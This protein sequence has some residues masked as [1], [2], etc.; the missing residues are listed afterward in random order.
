MGEMKRLFGKVSG[1]EVFLYTLTNSKGMN[2]E[3]SPFGAVVYS[4]N[5]ADKDGLYVDVT[6]GW[7]DLDGYQDNRCFYGAA[8]GRYANRIAG[9]RFVLGG[10]EYKLAQNDGNNHLHGGPKGYYNVLWD[11][12]QVSD[13]SITLIY[14][15]PDG[16]E[17]YPGNL[18][19]SL[20][21]T[22]T[23]DNALVLDY[24]AGSDA[25]TIVNLTNHTY[26]NLE[27]H[28]AGYIGE[29]IMQIFADR[30]IPTDDG[31]IP[32]GRLDSV[33]GTPYDFTRPKPIG[34]DIN[35]PDQQLKNGS[36]YDQCFVVSGERVGEHHGKPVR[37]CAQV[38]APGKRHC[39][40][41]G[42]YGRRTAVLFRQPHGRHRQTG[43][44]LR[45]ERSLLSGSGLFSQCGQ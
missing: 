40:A 11:V 37:L 2:V 26:F 19:I 43:N 12:A 34:L 23:E 33:S 6:A 32:Y 15:S 29:Q 17:G 36:G 18:D 7:D 14:H 28:S 9:G 20:T 38:S 4:I 24:E 25:D 1:R 27:G 5:V 22:V 45:R 30:Y 3:I 39:D 8:V 13:D 44:G 41:G 16:E 21:Y 35:K 10:K 31:G 42:K